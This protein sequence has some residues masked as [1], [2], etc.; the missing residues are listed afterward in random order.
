[1]VV[2]V[3]VVRLNGMVKIV[4]HCARRSKKNRARRALENV[5][6]GERRKGSKGRAEVGNKIELLS[7]LSSAL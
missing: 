4:V 3:T 5:F 2:V 1:M 7:L 6:L